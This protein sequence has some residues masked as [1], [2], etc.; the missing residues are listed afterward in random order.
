MFLLVSE[1]PEL[2]PHK[3][4]LTMKIVNVKVGVWET[5]T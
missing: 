5:G 2:T 1:L 3:R 4:A